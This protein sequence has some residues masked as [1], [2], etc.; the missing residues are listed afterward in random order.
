MEVDEEDD[1]QPVEQSKQR[2]NRQV[3]QVK[4]LRQTL[5]P[6]QL[7]RQQRKRQREAEAEEAK[8]KAEEGKR[9]RGVPW[10][11]RPWE[12]ET[13]NERSSSVELEKATGSA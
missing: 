2:R 8:P 4:S 11:T 5:T 12:A 13:T 7:R 6:S 3:R 9:A 1:M 10:L